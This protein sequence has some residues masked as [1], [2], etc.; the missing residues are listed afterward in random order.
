MPLKV[1][2]SLGD[3]F[4]SKELWDLMPKVQCGSTE[5]EKQRLLSLYKQIY[6]EYDPT[7]AE[8]KNLIYLYNTI[9]FR[10]IEEADIIIISCRDTVVTD[11]FP[12]FRPQVVIVDDCHLAEEAEAWIPLLMYED[13][14]FRIL[15]GNIGG[16]PP[17]TLSADDPNTQRRQPSLLERMAVMEV[18]G[19]DCNASKPTCSTGQTLKRVAVGPPCRRTNLDVVDRGGSTRSAAGTVRS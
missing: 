4:A 3:L 2:P 6:N 8:E 16:P 1:D 18:P 13:A 9:Y 11:F 14:R 7:V 5:D 15:L 10:V 17:H 12:F 19:Y